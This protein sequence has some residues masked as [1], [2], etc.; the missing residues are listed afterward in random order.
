M[1][2]TAYCAL[3][4]AVLI[5]ILLIAFSIMILE[6]VALWFV[7]E[8]AGEPGWAAIIPIYNYL[9]VIK[10][11]GKPWWF[12]L[13]MLIPIVNLVIYIIILNGLSRNFGKDEAFTVG[14]FFLRFIFLPILGFGKAQY[15]GDKSNFS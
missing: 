2:E 6:I 1:D 7:L 14:L 12:I 15:S 10:I 3:G 4:L 5:P 13:M 8:K 9:M 11:A